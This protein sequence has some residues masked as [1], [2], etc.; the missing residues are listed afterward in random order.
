MFDEEER[1]MDGWKE[2]TGVESGERTHCQN[3]RFHF[4]ACDLSRLLRGHGKS[5]YGLRFPRALVLLTYTVS[6]YS[7]SGIIAAINWQSVDRLVRLV[8][9]CLTDAVSL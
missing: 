8:N 2:R 7:C 4:R 5:G 1:R 3:D 6:N 9:S